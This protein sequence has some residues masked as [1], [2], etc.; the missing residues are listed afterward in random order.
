LA[1]SKKAKLKRE[2]VLSTMGL[3]QV[4]MY[5]RKDK[6]RLISLLSGLEKDVRLLSARRL[7]AKL[8]M[9]KGLVSYFMF[10]VYQPKNFDQA[11]RIAQAT[12]L[13]VLEK[14]LL[15]IAIQVSALAGNAR[16]QAA[17]Q[18]LL[19]ELLVREDASDLYLV[20]PRKDISTPFQISLVV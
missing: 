9:I 10:D 17:F 12:G 14:Q 1:N 19:D 5:N 18:K 15:D 20:K 11:I 7:K 6:A 8:A 4:L 2:E 13:Q 3:I 16:E